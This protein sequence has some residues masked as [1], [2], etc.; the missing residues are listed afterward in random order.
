MPDADST[1]DSGASTP[2]TSDAGIIY[3]ATGQPQDDPDPDELTHDQLL[4]SIEAETE[5]RLAHLPPAPQVAWEIPQELYVK[6]WKHQE[7]LTADERQL[8]L[9]RGDA[10]GKALARPESLTPEEHNILLG[11]APPDAVRAAI[12]R[13][14][15]GTLHT[16]G[17]LFAKASAARLNQTS[18]ND[19]EL[20]L[21][22]MNFPPDVYE[23]TLTGWCIPE[24]E[25]PGNQEAKSLL[26][27]RVCGSDRGAFMYMM[28]LWNSGAR[29]RIE[30]RALWAEQAKHQAG[31]PGLLRP[32]EL[33]QKLKWQAFVNRN[34]PLFPPVDTLQGQAPVSG[35]A[36]PIGSVPGSS[37]FDPSNLQL[38]DPTPRPA[39]PGEG[40]VLDSIANSVEKALG[41]RERGEISEEA[42]MHRIRSHIFNLRS[43]ARRQERFEPCPSSIQSPMA[44][45]IPSSTPPSI[46]SFIP[47]SVPQLPHRPPP[48]LGMPSPQAGLAP[49][50]FPSMTAPSVAL[51]TQ[52]AEADPAVP[53]PPPTGLPDGAT[54]SPLLRKG[55]TDAELYSILDTRLVGVRMDRWARAP[56]GNLTWP[57]LKGTRKMTPIALFSDDLKEELEAQGVVMQDFPRY[58]HGR[59]SQLAPEQLASYEARSEAIRQEQWDQFERERRENTQKMVEMARETW[60]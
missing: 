23:A 55:L 59:F 40:A 30:T 57:Y 26:Y 43:T 28:I 2:G 10:V 7:Q 9:S 38:P 60:Q 56:S 39:V 37:G 3:D 36:L 42:F 47:S 16:P 4:A 12:E 33:A 13:A 48:S 20:A 25:T 1:S 27:A 58:L 44:P 24:R 54:P 34:P 45:S 53:M 32:D 15:G 31:I 35:T 41:L 22:M 52:N 46:P 6:A 29:S 51:P 21:M 8:L 49:P 17:E 19:E 11:W 5:A 18:L 14:S 50:V